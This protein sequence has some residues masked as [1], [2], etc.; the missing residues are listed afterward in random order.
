MSTRHFYF[1]IICYIIG[2]IGLSG[3]IIWLYQEN[4]SPIFIVLTAVGILMFGFQILHSFDRI[5]EKITYFF[6]AVENEDS[7]LYYSEKV[8]HKPLRELHRSLNRINTLIQDAKVKNREQEQYFA[9]LLE[10]VVTGIVVINENGNILQANSAAKKLL[11]Y[12][13]LTHIV[14]LKR[15]DENLYKAF[16][17][18]A[19]GHRQLIKLTHNNTTTQLTLQAS[20][21][22]SRNK[23]FLLVA[24]QDIRNELDAKE[25][26]SWLKLIRVLTHEIM[27]SITPITS[28]SDTLLSYYEKG[29]TSPSAE[30]IAN[31]VKG[32]EV[33]RERGDGLIR[34]VTSYRKLTKISPPILKTIEAKP[35]L[36]HIILL[37]A[38]ES[39]QVPIH[40]VQNI[41]PETLTLDADEGQLSQVL[42]NLIKNAIQAVESIENPTIKIIAKLNKNNRPQIIVSDNGI[43]IPEEIIEQ[44]FIPFFTTKENG[45]GIGLSLSRQIMRNHSGTIKVVSKQAKGSQFVLEF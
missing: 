15:V 31:T 45:S 20:S 40:F 43:G 38:N 3:L 13:T 37:V 8:P 24:I 23:N 44:I 14:Q 18:L 2:L 16:T 41:T 17:M 7:T 27:N 10:Q 36:E 19:E 29:T 39:T 11:N 30:T 12:S 21:F 25:V 32:L 35:F 22:D 33:I 9:A 5:Q 28:L 1:R 42:I 6:N 4:T 26:E 34:F